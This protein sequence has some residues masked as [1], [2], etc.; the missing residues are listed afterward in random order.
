MN[1][2]LFM[3]QFNSGKLRSTNAPIAGQIY[4]KFNIKEISG[5]MSDLNSIAF[6]IVSGSLALSK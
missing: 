3:I 5:N 6:P 2:H 4:V 1:I